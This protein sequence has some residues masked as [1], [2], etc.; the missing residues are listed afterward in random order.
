MYLLII[1]SLCGLIVTD[2][3]LQSELHA[4]G[5]EGITH[6]RTHVNCAFTAL[7]ALA[8]VPPGFIGVGTAVCL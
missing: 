1:N 8:P 5:G 4:G 2:V 7:M 6:S 3:F